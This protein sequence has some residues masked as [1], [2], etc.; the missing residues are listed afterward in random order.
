MPKPRIDSSTDSPTRTGLTR[1]S[2]FGGIEKR[3]AAVRF[4]LQMAQIDLQ[5]AKIMNTKLRF[6]TRLL[7]GIL[8]ILY[9]PLVFGFAA[10]GHRLVALIAEEH[11][12]TKTRQKVEELLAPAT[13]ADVQFMGG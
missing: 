2:P 6:S 10:E 11:L 8:T 1:I 13:M 9:S 3:L 12:T 5:K 4:L 7:V